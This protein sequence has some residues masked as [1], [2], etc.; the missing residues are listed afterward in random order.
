MKEEAKEVLIGKN[1]QLAINIS[2]SFISIFVSI[3]I[4]FFLSPYLVRSVGVEAYGFVQLGSNIV[5][6]LAVLAIALHSM[7]SRFIS[8]AYFRNDI[9]SANEYYSSTFYSNLFLSILFT[10]AFLVIILNIMKLVNISVQ[11]VVDVQFLIG[12]LAVNFLIGLLTINLSVP[13]YITNKLYL[14]SLFQII[15]HLLRAVLMIVLYTFFPPYVAY[16][17]LVSIAVTV[18]TQCV[19]IYWKKKLIPNLLIK[20]TF[21]KLSRVKV[22]ISSGIWNA[23][24][25]MGTIFSEGLDLLITNVMIGAIQMGVL[26]IAKIIPNLFN[27]MI[28]SLIAT[29]MPTMTELYA[30]EKKREL[31]NSV[32]QSMR[33]VSFLINIPISLLIA[34]GDRLFALW[35]PTQDPQLLHALSVISII[36]WTFLGLASIIH[37]VF[38]IVNRIRTNSIL[39][40]ICGFINVLIVFILLK[41][42]DY[43]LYAVASVSAAINIL[44]SLLYTLPYGAKYLDQPW[45]TFFPEVGRSVLSVLFVSSL[46]LIMKP[47]FQINSWLYLGFLATGLLIIGFIANAVIII[48]RQDRRYIVKKIV[49]FVQ[50]T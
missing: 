47:L 1:K 31:V 2:A 10:P 7:S 41:S 13:Y 37:N 21:F 35:F 4:N 20:R 36:P 24:T 23:I 12:F 6:Y 19:N 26:S 46:G 30:I 25:R 49:S 17:G 8:I 27:T 32:K 42:T 15:S 16:I 5:S 33:I 45:Y 3:G 18:F 34:F 28:N 48:N 38:T 9:Q 29:F 44:R 14:Y 11:L 40:T 50:K 39:V 22:L 43:G